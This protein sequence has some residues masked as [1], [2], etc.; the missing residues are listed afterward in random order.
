MAVSG[1]EATSIAPGQQPFIGQHSDAI[2]LRFYDAAPHVRSTPVDNVLKEKSR[3]L[4][5]DDSGHGWDLQCHL[6]NA[7]HHKHYQPLDLG[8]TQRPIF[9]LARVRWP[10]EVSQTSR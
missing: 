9:D 1:A 5:D 10:H 6:P 7:P 3:P 4:L 8:A 2:E